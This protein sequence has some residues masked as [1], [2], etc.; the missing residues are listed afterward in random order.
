MKYLYIVDHFVPFPIS[1]FGG[2]WTVIAEDDDECFDLIAKDDNDRYEKYYIELRE[3][4]VSAKKVPL[5][6]GIESQVV[7]CF[8]T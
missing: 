3:R 6:D 5:A 2:T 8:L 7:D 4:V 1:E